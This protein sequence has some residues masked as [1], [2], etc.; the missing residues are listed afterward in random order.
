MTNREY[1]EASEPGGIVADVEANP[2]AAEPAPAPEATPRRYEVID[3]KTGEP[4]EGLSFILT[5]TGRQLHMLTEP[6]HYV[7]PLRDIGIYYYADEELTNARQGH[8]S[9]PILRVLSLWTMGR[10]I[11]REL[12]GIEAGRHRGRQY[13][14]MHRIK[15]LGDLALRM[16]GE[17]RKENAE[18]VEA[19]EREKEERLRRIRAEYHGGTENG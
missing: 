8:N 10:R 4:V 14:N 5:P 9:L 3:A 1:I 15:E 13:D 12:A 17:Y 16:W 19:H 11:F 18:F 6:G 2:E 7:G